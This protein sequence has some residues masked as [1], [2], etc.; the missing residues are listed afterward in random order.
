[1]S[2]VEPGCVHA[3]R[4]FCMSRTKRKKEQLPF[5]NRQGALILLGLAALLVLL[6]AITLHWS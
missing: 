3:C 4:A 6:L 5:T 2:D 1:M